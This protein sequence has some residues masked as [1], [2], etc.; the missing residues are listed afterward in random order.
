[1]EKQL[2]QADIVLRKKSKEKPPFSD[3]GLM[4]VVMH[5]RVGEIK[6]ASSGVAEDLMHKVTENHC[7]QG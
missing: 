6:A 1:M 3:G 2:L 4:I 7:S 5:W